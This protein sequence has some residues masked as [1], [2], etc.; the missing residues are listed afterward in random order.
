MSATGFFPCDKQVTYSMSGKMN[1]RS[2][3][4]TTR[5]FLNGEQFATSK[6]TMKKK[7]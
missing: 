3:Q 5:I 6:T 1:S 4:V 2:V 7:R